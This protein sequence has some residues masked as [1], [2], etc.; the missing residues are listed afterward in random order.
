MM[1]KRKMNRNTIKHLPFNVHRCASIV[2]LLWPCIQEM[3][4]PKP[5]RTS[6]YQPG[7]GGA[8]GNKACNMSGMSKLYNLGD[9]KEQA[10]DIEANG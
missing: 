4:V 6:L 3:L 9:D 5:E 8:R 10:K 2:S 7:Y 1:T